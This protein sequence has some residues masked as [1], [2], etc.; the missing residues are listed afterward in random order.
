MACKTQGL[1]GARLLGASGALRL[2]GASQP[3]FQSS[4]GSGWALASLLSTF[5]GQRGN[6]SGSPQACARPLAELSWDRCRPVH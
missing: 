3:A 5:H 2:K 1:A 4:W 6:S